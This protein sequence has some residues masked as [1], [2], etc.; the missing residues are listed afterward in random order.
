MTSKPVAFCSPTW[1]S[2]RLIAP[3]RLERPTPFIRSAVQDAEVTGR[4]SLTGS[5]RS[6]TSGRTATS[7]SPCCTTPSTS[8]WSF[9]LLTPSDCITV[10]PS[11]RVAARSHRAGRGVRR[12]TLERFSRR[13]SPTCR[14]LP[15]KCGSPAQAPW[16]HA[17][18]SEDPSHP[19]CPRGHPHV[20]CPRSLRS[21]NAC[22]RQGE[23]QCVGGQSP[24]RLRLK[25]GDR[26]SA[27]RRRTKQ[28]GTA[29]LEKAPGREPGAGEGDGARSFESSRARRRI[30]Q[31]I[32]S[33]PSLPALTRYATP[34]FTIVFRFGRQ[35]L[36]RSRRRWPFARDLG[37]HPEA[38][39][40]HRLGRQSISALALLER[41][42]GQFADAQSQRRVPARR[43]ARSSVS[44][45]AALLPVPMFCGATWRSAPSCYHD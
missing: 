20:A 19:T 21:R 34:T 28:P 7:S 12:R 1:G 45:I 33:T 23:V 44:A 36:H 29:E 37:R 22:E 4:R 41:R 42:V 13:P 16:T 11:R 17:G 39:I 38:R 18:S 35:M 40:L 25:P 26:S 27:S 15:W 31:P 2:R 10:W 14:S 9:G 30:I 5:A 6:R 8:F 32:V 24:R 43:R 3:P